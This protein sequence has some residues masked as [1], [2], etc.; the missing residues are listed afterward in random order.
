MEDGTR[1][2]LTTTGDYYETM[3]TVGDGGYGGGGGGT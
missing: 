1:I 3:P 2:Y